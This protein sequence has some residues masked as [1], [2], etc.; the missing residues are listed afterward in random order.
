MSANNETNNNNQGITT[1][2]TVFWNNH[3]GDIDDRNIL[4]D[5]IGKIWDIQT[6]KQTPS[7]VCRVAPAVTLHHIPIQHLDY[8]YHIR[9]Y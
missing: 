8:F 2:N 3:S 5:T 4:V 1:T 9:S 6:H 7:G